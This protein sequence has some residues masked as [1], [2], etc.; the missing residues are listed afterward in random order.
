MDPPESQGMSYTD[1]IKRR[2]EEKGCLYA[3]KILSLALSWG[4]TSLAPCRKMYTQA[5]EVS[6]VV[7]STDTKLT[8]LLSSMLRPEILFTV[9]PGF[10]TTFNV[11]PNKESIRLPPSPAR[12]ERGITSNCLRAT[13]EEHLAVKNPMMTNVSPTTVPPAAAARSP[14]LVTPP[15][16]PLRTG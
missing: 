8:P 3:A 9:G 10:P 4:D 6:R 7:S 13:S 15:F 1:H 11:A 16:V 14:V 2:H 12:A 5:T